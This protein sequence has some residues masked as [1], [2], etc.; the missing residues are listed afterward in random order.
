ML[1][2]DHEITERE[3]NLRKPVL[4]LDKCYK[5]DKIQQMSIIS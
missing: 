1:H 4:V 5:E 3:E 2:R